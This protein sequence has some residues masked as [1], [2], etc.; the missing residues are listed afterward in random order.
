LLV[1]SLS[2]VDLKRSQMTSI[3]FSEFQHAPFRKG[4]LF[5]I[6]QL[7]WF[8]ND[9]MGLLEGGTQGD[10]VSSDGET[11][12]PAAPF[13]AEGIVDNASSDDEDQAETITKQDSFLSFIS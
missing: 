11:E 12:E 6:N 8:E 9:R 4:W 2:N 10:L 7:F 13:L 1:E 5:K 3:G